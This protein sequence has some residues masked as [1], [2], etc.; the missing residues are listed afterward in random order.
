MSWRSLTFHSLCWFKYHPYHFTYSSYKWDNVIFNILTSLSTFTFALFY[1][2]Q[3]FRQCSV[4]LIYVVCCLSLHLHIFCFR[5]TDE[6][7]SLESLYPE[8]TLLH[9][10]S[11][12]HNLPWKSLPGM[13]KKNAK[14]HTEIFNKTSDC[15]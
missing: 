7:V 13:N 2:P 5:A 12:L 4:P 10:T 8:E 1:W 15:S 6:G 14:T 11:I 3:N 9:W